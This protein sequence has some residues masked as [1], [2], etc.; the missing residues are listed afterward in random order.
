MKVSVQ[1]AK[2]KSLELA[3]E[4]SEPMSVN[5]LIDRSEKIYQYIFTNGKEDASDK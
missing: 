2:L 5:R 4:N 3:L 1:E